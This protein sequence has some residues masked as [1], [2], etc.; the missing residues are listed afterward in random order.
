MP[1]SEV[2]GTARGDEERA[3][4]LGMSSSSQVSTLSSSA[5]TELTAVDCSHLDLVRLRSRP[6]GWEGCRTISRVSGSARYDGGSRLQGKREVGSEAALVIRESRSLW[7]GKSPLS[8]R[9]IQAEVWS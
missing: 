5:V 1:Q 3:S 9:M 8:R 6:S 2:Q 4:L 7:F